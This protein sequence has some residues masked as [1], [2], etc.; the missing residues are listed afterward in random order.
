MGF[1]N[2]KG[3]LEKPLWVIIDLVILFLVFYYS[4]SYVDQVT[5]RIGFEKAYLS[6]DVVLLINTIYAAPSDIELQYRRIPYGSAMG[7]S[8]IG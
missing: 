7:L 5:S 1:K 2:K 3:M 4:A 8:I 6:R